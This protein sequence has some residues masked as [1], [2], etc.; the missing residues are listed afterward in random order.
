M[1]RYISNQILDRLWKVS[2]RRCRI[3]ASARSRLTLKT[4]HEAGQ[5]ETV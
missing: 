4:V 5:G 1:A 3:R 2:D